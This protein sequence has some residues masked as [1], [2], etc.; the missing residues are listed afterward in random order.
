MTTNRVQILIVED[1]A[2]LALDL[3]DMLEAEGYTVIG[4]ARTGRRALELFEQH[5]VD[6]LL[7]DIHIQGELDGIETA[8]AVLAQR[9]VPVIY[10]TALGDKD[11]LDR[12]LQTTP[13]AYMTKPATPTGLRAAIELALHTFARQLPVPAVLPAAAPAERESLSRESILQLDDHVFIKYNHQ[14]VRIPLCDI[15]LLEA[16][17]TY[18]TLVTPTRKYALRLTLTAMLERLQFPQLVRVHRSHAVNIQRVESFSETEATVAGQ[19]V[20][21]GRQYKEAF[22]QHFQFR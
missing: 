12:A 15:L 18:T 16:D 13:A 22:L 10:L 11:T 1:E 6:L 2:V 7:C 4:P 20:P 9:A 21:L 5:P 14:F 3:S 8:R 17:N 19:L